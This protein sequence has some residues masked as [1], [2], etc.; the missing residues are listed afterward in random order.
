M[1]K[2]LVEVVLGVLKGT[3]FTAIVLAAPA[4]FWFD[5]IGS[6]VAPLVQP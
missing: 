6:F 5:E 2:V 4:Y 1:S 3:I